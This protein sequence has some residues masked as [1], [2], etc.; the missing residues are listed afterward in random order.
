MN[1]FWTQTP[2]SPF[3]SYVLNHL[4]QSTLCAA[5]AWLFTLTLL[6]NNR[7]QI[8]YSVWLAASLKF[9]L[10]F[11][12]LVTLGSRS[13][14]IKLAPASTQ[15]SIYFAMD[16]ASRLPAPRL[17]STAVLP[18]KAHTHH[19]SAGAPPGHLG[20]RRSRC[21]VSLVARV[22]PRSHGGQRRQ[23]DGYLRRYLRALLA[24]TSRPRP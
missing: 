22:A 9:L 11:A 16:E 3:L 17:V 14:W 6:R 4:W 15:V 23:P 20:M 18:T 21:V 2:T 1:W 8:R 24:C 10:P 13:G 5:V 19:S 7:A 12:A